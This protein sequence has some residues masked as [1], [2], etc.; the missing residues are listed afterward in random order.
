MTERLKNWKLLKESMVKCPKCK[1]EIPEDSIFCT[2]CGVN[3]KQAFKIEKTKS[4]KE[5]QEKK[6]EVSE[7]RENKFPWNQ[8]VSVSLITA[9]SVSV[10]FYLITNHLA[11]AYGIEIYDSVVLSR[12]IIFIILAICISMG[13]TYLFWYLPRRYHILRRI[14]E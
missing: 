10:I 14:E 5:L 11:D 1:T 8:V 7:K 6:E 13:I 9:I 3:L 12:L 2:S 4:K